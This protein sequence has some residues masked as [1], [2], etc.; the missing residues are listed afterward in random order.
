MDNLWQLG[1]E[2]RGQ[3]KVAED[4]QWSLITSKLT[5]LTRSKAERMNNLELSKNSIEAKPWDKFGYQ[6]DNN[7]LE[8]LNLG[9][10]NLDLKVNEAAVK[11]PFYSSVYNM[12]PVYQKSTYNNINSFKMNSGINTYG[13]KLNGKEA[14]N[15]I[16]AGNSNSNN[17]NNNS[18]NN[19]SVDKRFKTLPSAEMLPRN[20]VLG[21]YIFVCNNDTMQEDL[22]RQLFGM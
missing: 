4:H 1:D 21:G 17:S 18:N 11:S 8:N 13:S 6:D 9:L 10:M 19:A 22:K 15:N 14:N 7:K 2:F 20:E 16:N 5:E 3:S 12:N